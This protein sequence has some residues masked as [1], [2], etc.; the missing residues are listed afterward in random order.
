[1]FESR[2]PAD[3]I[4]TPFCCQSMTNTIAATVRLPTLSALFALSAHL[5]RVESSYQARQVSA[6]RAGHS[7]RTLATDWG[8]TGGTPVSMD[9]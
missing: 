6:E 8:K 5:V 1:M 4:L 9:K 2:S 7:L 3:R